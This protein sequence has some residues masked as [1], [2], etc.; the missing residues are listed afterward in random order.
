MR[1]AL[2]T[3]AALNRRHGTGA[4]LLRYLDGLELD[5]AHLHF[6]GWAGWH[7]D[8]PRS[9]SLA[10][11]EWLERHHRF[12][13]L[14]RRLGLYWWRYGGLRRSTRAAIRHTL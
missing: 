9:L 7:S 13:S 5:Y 3:E 6:L 10:R 14:A 4:Q 12:R 11:P 2:V 1:V 8:S